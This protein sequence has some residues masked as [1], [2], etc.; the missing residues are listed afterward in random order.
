MITDEEQRA[1]RGQEAEG[2][3]WCRTSQSQRSMGRVSLAEKGMRTCYGEK[4]LISTS[5]LH[6]LNQNISKM[7]VGM[8]QRGPGYH[9]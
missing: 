4:L 3:S 1:D 8:S 5:I 6:S 9:L 7:P 2:S